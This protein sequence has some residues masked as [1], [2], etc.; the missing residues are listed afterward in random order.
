[1]QTLL[2]KLITSVSIRNTN[3]K[4]IIYGLYSQCQISSNFFLTRSFLHSDILEK[5][6][7]GFG[8]SRIGYPQT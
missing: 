4:C 2:T 6:T 8:M 7:T 3:Y 5:I 1:M